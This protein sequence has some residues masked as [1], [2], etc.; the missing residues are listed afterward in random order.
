MSPFGFTGL[1]R[2]D[3]FGVDFQLRRRFDPIPVNQLQIAEVNEEPQRLS[4]HKDRVLPMHSVHQQHDTAGNA[5]IPER[6]RNNTLLFTLTAKPLHDEPAR[7]HQLA[8]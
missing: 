1:L 2:S 8:D 6:H 4:Q 3:L 7:E 5:Q